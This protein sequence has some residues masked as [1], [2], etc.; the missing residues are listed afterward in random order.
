MKALIVDDDVFVR[1]CITTMVPWEELGF[2]S[3]LEADNGALALE[4]ALREK[5]DF[6]ISD[7]KMPVMSGLELSQRLRD[8]MVDT[9]VIILSEY[10]D[11]QFVQKAMNCGVQD[12]ILKPI[13]RDR[14]K[15]LTERIRQATADLEKRRYCTSLITDHT[16]LKAAIQDMLAKGDVQTGLE[17]LET[18]VRHDIHIDDL[19]RFCLL[20]LSELFSQM[21]AVAFRRTELAELRDASFSHF[22]ELKNIEDILSF[23]KEL[24][25]RC[26]HLGDRQITP[27]ENYVQQIIQ[28]IE[29]NYADPDLSV[30][31]ISELLH[32]STVYTGAL[33]KKHQGRS[34]LSQIHEVRLRHATEML[35]DMSLSISEISVRVGYLTPDYFTRVFRRSTG[36]TPSEYQAMLL[37]QE[38][39]P[40]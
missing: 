3:V 37:S 12:Y 2:S 27:T 39:P 40:R 10:N 32:L 33:F 13:T 9:C 36:M 14:L 4:T 5:P 26:I 8:S 16:R 1:L 7:V 31:K 6:I 28:Y 11:F 29:S 17:T 22:A 20:F 38:S 35:R 25:Q 34:L 23:T 19:K 18:A 21:E 15:E 30:A 24:C